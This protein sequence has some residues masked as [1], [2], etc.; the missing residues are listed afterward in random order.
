[1]FWEYYN[2][3][4]AY[5][6]VNGCNRYYPLGERNY[7]NEFNPASGALYWCNGYEG[8]VQNCEYASQTGF[9]TAT[10]VVA[11]GETSHYSTATPVE[12]G[13]TG[14]AAAVWITN[15]SY[16]KVQPNPASWAAVQSSGVNYAGCGYSPC[17]YSYNWG[18][19]ATV[20]YTYNWT[21]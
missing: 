14:Q 20:L 2:P 6:Y 11:Y 19:A 15:I 9:T 21:N 5:D 12:M 1:M 4:L 3:D 8:I 10:S 13:E 16:K 17:P 18:F 7:Y